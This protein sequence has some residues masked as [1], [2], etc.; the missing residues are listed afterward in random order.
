MYVLNWGVCMATFCTAGAKLELDGKME[1]RSMVEKAQ[2]KSYTCKFKLNVIYV[3]RF[4]PKEQF[5]SNVYA[6]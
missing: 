3:R 6:L 1:P 4:L 5:I 2:R